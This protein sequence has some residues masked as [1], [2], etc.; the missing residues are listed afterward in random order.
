MIK[1]STAKNGG[2]D[3]VQCK[4][5]LSEYTIGTTRAK[6]HLAGVTGTGVA[7]CKSAPPELRAQLIKEVS[8][9]L[10]LTCFLVLAFVALCDYCLLVCLAACLFVLL[11]A[12]VLVGSLTCLT[13]THS[14]HAPCLQGVSYVSMVLMVV[15]CAGKG[16]GRRERSC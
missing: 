6:A 15:C 8:Y 3:K 2:K 9:S 12:C 4:H 10:L 11:F 16:R 1:K 7:V 13:L 14:L 5:C